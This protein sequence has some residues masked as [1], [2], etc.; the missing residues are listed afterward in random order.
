VK[1]WAVEQGLTDT[2]PAALVKNSKVIDKIKGELENKSKGFKGYERIKNFALIED[3]FTTENGMLT[4]SMKLKR[5][6]VLSKY[7]DLVEGLYA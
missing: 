5:R 2:K 7:G 1:E 3:D 4:P 6:M